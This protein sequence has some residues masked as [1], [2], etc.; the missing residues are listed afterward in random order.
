MNV[1]VIKTKE[2]YVKNI[3]KNKIIYT[4][5]FDKAKPFNSSHKCVVTMA[6]NKPLF[7]ETNPTIIKI[8]LTINSITEVNERCLEQYQESK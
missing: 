4:S 3:F 1:F 8:G 5:T 2:G 7:K 6:N